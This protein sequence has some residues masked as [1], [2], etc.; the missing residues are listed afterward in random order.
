MFERLAL[1]CGLVLL[2]AAIP[3]GAFAAPAPRGSALRWDAPATCPSGDLL[4]RVAG[5]VGLSRA[6]LA[7]KLLRVDAVFGPTASGG[8]QAQLKVETVAGSGERSFAAE[9]CRSLVEGT[10]LILALA[11]DPSAAS[12]REP[13]ASGVATARLPPQKTASPRPD[14]LLRPLAIFWEEQSAARVLALCRLQREPQA[15]AEAAKLL[16]QA[17]R[18]PQ[19]ARLRSSCAAAAVNSSSKSEGE[20]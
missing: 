3:I 15:R 18:S 14:L 8:W 13:S 12:A 4:D 16:S 6:S 11:V 5:L 10:A 17:P 1:I 2:G 19:L 7:T 20:R 9:D